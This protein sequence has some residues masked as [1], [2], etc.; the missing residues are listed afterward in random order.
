MAKTRHSHRVSGLLIGAAVGDAL[1]APFEFKRAGQYSSTFP[2][3]FLGGIGEM[4]GGGSFN[5]REGEFT[6]DTQMA[7]SLALSIL[8][9]G[10]FDPDHVWSYWRVWAKGARDI[11]N[12]TRH[13]LNFA[14][15]L[16]VKHANPEM[17]A[18]NGALMR[19]FP[20]ALLDKPR[21]EIREIVLEQGQL[22]HPHPAA[23]WGAWLGVSMMIS[24]LEGDDP[25]K[26]L[27]YE[28]AAMPDDVAPPFR[29]K[30]RKSTRLNSSH[31]R[32]SRM[33]S[34]A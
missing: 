22:T 9:K 4:I 11:G 32:P 28:L 26:T 6:D 33:P 19:S 15:R 17:T 25:L 20:L 5:W 21:V 12:T 2:K 31:T 10:D 30:D 16:D 34:S 14:N 27:T 13:S 29:D 7:L 8:D 1:G 24:A 3:P 18:A 23:S